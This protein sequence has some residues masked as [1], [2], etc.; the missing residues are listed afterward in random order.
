MVG[1]IF[2]H[3]NPVKSKRVKRVFFLLLQILRPVIQSRIIYFI[4]LIEY[5]CNSR[6]PADYKCKLH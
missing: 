2:V 6:N 1:L 4:L 3:V 5:L